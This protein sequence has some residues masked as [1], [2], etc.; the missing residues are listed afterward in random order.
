M[1]ENYYRNILWTSAFPKWLR[2]PL[3]LWVRLKEKML[4]PFF[5]QIIFAEK[6]YR[7]EIRFLAARATVLEN[8]SVLPAGFVRHPVEGKIVLA[9]TGTLGESTGVFEAIKLADELYEKRG[10]I[11]LRIL[12]ACAIPDVLAEIMNRC[13]GKPYIRLTAGKMQVGHDRILDLISK[14]HFGIISYPPSPHTADRIPTKLFEYLSARLPILLTDNPAWHA[15]TDPVS[16]AIHVDFRDP[17]VEKILVEMARKDFYSGPVDEFLWT[18]EE[19]RLV[20]LV[21]NL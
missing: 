12:G 8:K 11:E 14:A 15:L 5:D 4:T 6:C 17:D 10:D 20:A 2:R 21:D 16:A 3:A 1:Q 7:N 13:S 9:F 19:P 18:S